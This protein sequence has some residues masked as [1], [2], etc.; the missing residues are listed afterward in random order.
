MPYEPITLGGEMATLHSV[1]RYDRRNTEAGDD[2]FVQF[3]LKA[4]KNLLFL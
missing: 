1:N 3:T 4:F 2:F